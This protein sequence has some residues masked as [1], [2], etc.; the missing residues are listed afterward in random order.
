[1]KKFNVILFGID[2]L[3]ADHLGCY[4]Y[5]RSTSPNIDS[6]AETGIRFGRC[7]SQAPKTAPSFMS[8]MTARYPTYHGI[9][10]NISGFGSD[11]RTYVL[12]LKVPTLAEILKSQ[13]YRTGAFTDGGNLYGQ[14][15]FDRGFDYYS[16]NSDYSNRN[17]MPGVIPEDEIA[18]WIRESKNENFFLFFHTFAVHNAWA[19]PHQ[20]PKVFANAYKGKLLV[21]QDLF[22]RLKVPKDRSPRRFFLDLVDIND[23][24]DI[25][26]LQA[27]YDGAI[28]YVDDFIG[29]ILAL[30]E[31]LTI[32]EKTLLIFTSD[33]GEE[34]LDHGMLS[35]RQLYNELLHVPLIIKAPQL[36]RPTVVSQHVRS[37]DIMPTALDLL[38]IKKETI[39]QGVSLMQTLEKDRGLMVIAEEESMGFSIM[40]KKYKYIYPKY[41]K[42][43]ITGE[44]YNLETDP[45]EK[46]NIASENYGL[47][48]DMRGRFEY[49]LHGRTP[50]PRPERKII[51]LSKRKER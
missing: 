3:R 12:D 16:E 21:E 40:D 43:M 46:I 30:L 14:V 8:I 42:E 5:R 49:E 48:E 35:H 11:V 20:Y 9:T 41:K 1:M 6:L 34:F 13:G 2:T 29:K 39:F 24:A 47:T 44:L 33:H 22:R 25:E 31:E 37:I 32:A 17:R 28:K 36:K 27:I 18:Y 51:Y 50:L 7:F 4:G 45:R 26:Y 38:G 19:V 10:S 15:G 23:P